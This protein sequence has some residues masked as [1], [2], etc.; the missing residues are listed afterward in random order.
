MCVH[1]NIVLYTMF[2]L[3]PYGLLTIWRK[4]VMPS[5]GC[6]TMAALMLALLKQRDKNN[7]RVPADGSIPARTL[8]KTKESF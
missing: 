3:T 7:S 4:L 8:E 2:I 5:S 1:I 6:N